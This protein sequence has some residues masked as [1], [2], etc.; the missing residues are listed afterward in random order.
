[1]LATNENL[2]EAVEKDTKP[3]TTT[4]PYWSLKAFIW[5]APK[6]HHG[7]PDIKPFTRRMHCNVFINFS[8]AIS[9]A[10][11]C[12]VKSIVC[13]SQKSLNTLESNARI[14]IVSKYPFGRMRKTI[15]S[16]LLSEITNWTD[17]DRYNN[18]Y[19]ISDQIVGKNHCYCWQGG[20][21]TRE[22]QDC[23]LG[24]NQ[25]ILNCRGVLGFFH[26]N[27]TNILLVDD[28]SL[29]YCSCYGWCRCCCLNAF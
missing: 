14:S 11:R 23:S 27:N 29:I 17:D 13:F 4:I 26:P 19:Y 22:E 16:L 12:I 1:M 25:I 24:T 28:D 10:R 3:P 9:V 5:G 7:W 8:F 15:S 20:C 6:F 21:R 2:P 18:N